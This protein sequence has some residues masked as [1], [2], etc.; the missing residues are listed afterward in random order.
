VSETSDA[1]HSELDY[2]W[3]AVGEAQESSALAEAEKAKAKAGLE[4]NASRLRR[5]EKALDV[6]ARRER[7]LKGEIEALKAAA[8]K[9]SE[10]MASA[11]RQAR[12][13][14]EAQALKLALQKKDNEAALLASDIDALKA[15]T[16]AL[17]EAVAGRETVIESLKEKLTGL[18]SLPELARTLK[19]DSRL[20]GKQRSVYEHLVERIEKGKRSA[21]AAAEELARAGREAESSRAALAAAEKELAGLRAEL[22]LR[23][24]ELSGLNAALTE[25]A[26]REKIS[27]EEKA[28]LE[29]RAA[30]LKAA[31]AEKET[32]LEASASALAAMKR[33]LESARA[34]A[35]RLK[36][37]ADEQALKTQEQRANFTGAV[38]Q[39]F[40]LQN[41]AKELRQE[42]AKAQEQNAALAAALKQ[43]DEDIDKVNGLL[44]ESRNSLAAEKESTRR[45]AVKIKSLEAEIEAL[46]AKVTAAG[47]YSGRL[48]K[49]VEERDLTL[50]AI[51]A[52]RRADQKKIDAVEAE[53][54]ELRRKSIK[55]AGF[56]Q[57]EQ[58]DFNSRIIAAM[59]KAVKDFKTFNL[60]IPAAERKALEPAMKNLFASVNLLKGWQEYMDPETPELEDADLA[61][62]VSGETAKWERAFKQRKLSVAAAVANPRLRARVS[63]ERVKMLF[64]HLIKNAYEHLPSGGSLRVYLKS[65]EDGRQAVITFEDNGPGFPREVLDKLYA[66]FNTSDKGRVGIGLAVARRIAEK[67]GGTL[68]ASNRK[69]RGAVV[70]VR[71][72]LG[73]TAPQP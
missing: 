42:L 16:A 28:A 47:E 8:A 34:E 40:E 29:G 61:P 51:K 27:A 4:E 72:P 26:G 14:G 46:K 21:A 7:E 68:E 67:H 59:E 17:R 20:S 38:G 70:E 15:E 30:G 24:D 19:E 71:I 23:K 10:F 73:A 50:G 49:A 1:F 44:R 39:V 48:L 3:R 54:E 53:N 32:S 35:D 62:L 56:L 66:P 22:A 45:A 13:A 18:T 65:S 36:A 60:R 2:L 37:A 31:L 25:A 69:E 57:Q 5:L 55:F 33:D 6:A 11:A 52:E 43:R 12:E 9:D 64:Y 41:R 58:A 63:T